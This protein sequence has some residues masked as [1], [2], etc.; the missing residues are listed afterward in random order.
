MTITTRG[1]FIDAYNRLDKKRFVYPWDFIYNHLDTKVNVKLEFLN[2]KTY[3]ADFF[4][5][6]IYNNSLP[7]RLLFYKDF[8][9]SLGTE[10]QEKKVKYLYMKDL[11]SIEII[12]TKVSEAYNNIVNLKKKDNRLSPA[13]LLDI[14]DE[15]NKIRKEMGKKEISYEEAYQYLEKNSR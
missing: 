6:T 10:K 8:K 12:D 7:D 2:G 1:E 13:V 3:N 9:Y 11:F 14:I 4:V 15:F 5:E